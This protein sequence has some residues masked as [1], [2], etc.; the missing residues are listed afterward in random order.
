MEQILDRSSRC[1]SGIGFHQEYHER[2]IPLDYAVL[3]GSAVLS[4]SLDEIEFISYFMLDGFLNGSPFHDLYLPEGTS[5]SFT[6]V[7]NDSFIILK[8]CNQKLGTVLGQNKD[9]LIV[10]AFSWTTIRFT[11]SYKLPELL[12]LSLE[13]DF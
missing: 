9:I 8:K 13:P 12:S 6:K 11:S 1:S 4:L 2:L 5:N 7:I 3:E 10:L